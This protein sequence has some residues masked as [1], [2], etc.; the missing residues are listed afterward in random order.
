MAGRAGEGV[1]LTGVQETLFI[2]L[3]AKALDA[4]QRHPILNDRKADEL[5]RTIHFD[6][7]RLT[8]TGS[9]QLLVVRAR[10][11]DEWVCRFLSGH[12]S[13]LILNLGCGLDAR[14]LR[15]GPPPSTL[16][17]D[18]DFPEVIDVRRRFYAERD[19]YRM[20]GA[21]LTEPGWLE[22]FPADRPVLVVGD[23]VF[24][25]L[26][27]AE[28]QSLFL[29]LTSHFREGEL[30]FDTMSS[31]ALAQGNARLGDRTTARL[32]FAV[33]DLA[34][35]DALDPKLRRVEVVSLLRS[36]YHPWGLRIIYTLATLSRGL[37]R[38][39]QL[40]RYDFPSDAARA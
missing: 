1:Q 36:P 19:G 18:L 7:E 6:F 3:Y 22:A 28:I 5:V 20:V 29:R 21:S 15:I 35:L 34:T 32:R 8:G 24:E 38:V 2:P 33:D 23:G 25:Y 14:I 27:P 40:V 12:P 4:R 16:W 11:L 30:V 31:A 13:A 39:I 26:E 10:H 9:R 17:I 37:R